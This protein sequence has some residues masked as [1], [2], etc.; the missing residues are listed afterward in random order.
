MK[1][2]LELL[3][4]WNACERALTWFARDYPDGVDAPVQE[5]CDKV[6]PADWRKYDS[7]WL[8]HEVAARVDGKDGDEAMALLVERADGSRLAKAVLEIEKRDTSA[9]LTRLLQVGDAA[10]LAQVIER[11]TDAQAVQAAE[12]LKAVDPAA[13]KGS[14]SVLTGARAALVQE[15][16]RGI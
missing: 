10:N 16:Q 6:I 13:L 1:I 11:G 4:E 5:L 8:L 9:A 12:A 3:K 7:L 14:E 15:V 2:T